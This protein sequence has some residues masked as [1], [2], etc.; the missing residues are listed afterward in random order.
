MKIRIKDWFNLHK[1][2]TLKLDPGVTVLVGPNGA[3]KTT[4]LQQLRERKKWTGPTGQMQ[5]VR[6]IFYSNLSDGGNIAMSQYLM[7][8]DMKMLAS[9]A[10]ASEGEAVILNFGQFVSKIRGTVKKADREG[11]ALMVLMDAVDS[12][13]SIDKLRI[14]SDLLNLIEQDTKGKE[15]YLIISTNAYELTKGRRCVDPRTGKGVVFKNY[16][17]YADFICNYLEEGENENDR[18]GGI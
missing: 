18:N 14:L 10:G 13:L 1:G 8:G 17:E 9:A 6:S 3:G 16:E 12:G 4:L 5:E 7:C 2:F 11:A 15:V